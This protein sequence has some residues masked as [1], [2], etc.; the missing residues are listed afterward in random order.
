[1][2]DQANAIK[3]NSDSSQFYYDPDNK[4][5]SKCGKNLPRTTKYFQRHKRNK[6]GVRVGWSAMCNDCHAERRA[7]RRAVVASKGHD[8]EK[9]FQ[10]TCTMCK[11][12]K[13]CK[14]FHKNRYNLDGYNFHCKVCKNVY[15]YK[16]KYHREPIP[17]R[18]CLRCERNRMLKFFDDDST[19]CIPCA[20]KKLNEEKIAEFHRINYKN[21]LKLCSTCKSYKDVTNFKYSRV[22]MD[23]LKKIC[24]ECDERIKGENVTSNNMYSNK[25]STSLRKGIEFSIEKEDFI[26]WYKNNHQCAY[27]GSTEEEFLSLKKV[28]ESEDITSI[29]K[30]LRGS[31]NT[32]R[33]AIDRID[34]D[35][36]YS[37]DNINKACWLCNSTKN[38]IFDAEAMKVIGK[39][40]RK[41][42]V[43]YLYS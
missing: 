42:Y 8:Y 6:E 22:Y 30:L 31:N 7:H 32:R 17:K 10:K 13:N 2:A 1:M 9:D 26:E 36:G 5:C 20:A 21:D 28:A 19:I 11:S 38:C 41:I 43:K 40:V 12:T 15:V 18:K 33:L 16:K 4:I 3:F 27:C 39:E 14:E 24:K 25:R 29:N 35:K 37:T 34:S 23:K